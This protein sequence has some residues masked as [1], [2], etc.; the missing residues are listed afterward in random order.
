MDLKIDL[1]PIGLRFQPGEQLRFVISLRNLLGTL[2]P[3][4]REYVGADAGQHV[5]HTGGQNA[6]YLQLP[7]RT[8]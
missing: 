4:I 8:R 2:M 1:L 6:S 7:V 3:G 5:F